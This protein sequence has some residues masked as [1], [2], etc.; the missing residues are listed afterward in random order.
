MTNFV[1]RLALLVAST[2]PAAAQHSQDHDTAG[3]GTT[4][5]PTKTTTPGQP[6]KTIKIEGPVPDQGKTSI[7]QFWVPPATASER[8]PMT[9]PGTAPIRM[10]R[11]PS[12]RGQS[13]AAP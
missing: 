7:L 2:L 8:Q 13:I 9:A 3:M 5:L 4:W 1:C 12:T 11:V 10:L 6:V